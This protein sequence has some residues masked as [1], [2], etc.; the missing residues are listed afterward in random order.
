MYSAKAFFQLGKH[1]YKLQTL[2]VEK[3]NESPQGNRQKRKEKK[4]LDS[5]WDSKGSL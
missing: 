2:I 5:E 4:N 1:T 3:A